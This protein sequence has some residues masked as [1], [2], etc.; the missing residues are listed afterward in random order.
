MA[1][2]GRH[3]VGERVIAAAESSSPQE[4]E[5][6][7]LSLRAWVHAW[8]R[9]GEGARGQRAWLFPFCQMLGWHTD[10]TFKYH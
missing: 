10:E 3:L 2:R 4:L 8:Q 5:L 1:G 6:K 7:F 9:L